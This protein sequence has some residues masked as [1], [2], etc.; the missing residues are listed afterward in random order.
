MKKKKF[1]GSAPMKGK[2]K[3]VVSSKG[4]GRPA[5]SSA[6]SAVPSASSSSGSSAASAGASGASSSAGGAMKKGGIVKK[7]K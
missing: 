4:T 6:P 2:T 1:S 5:P 3:T 7:K